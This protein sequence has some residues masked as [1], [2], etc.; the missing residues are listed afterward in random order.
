MHLFMFHS[1]YDM[2]SCIRGFL[3]HEN[4]VNTLFLHVYKCIKMSVYIKWFYTHYIHALYIK[5]V[6]WS[7]FFHRGLYTAPL[8]SR[9]RGSRRTV[10]YLL[11][12]ASYIRL[13]YKGYSSSSSNG[14]SS[15][16][17]SGASNS[18]NRPKL[19]ASSMTSQR[20][21]FN[22]GSLSRSKLTPLLVNP[23]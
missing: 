19:S 23:V 3:T 14:S 13:L 10:P 16:S 21:A 6:L 15:G 7:G 20:I 1:F 22:S 17:S 18:S 9:L 11:T 4:N 2:I 5:G 8:P 12:W